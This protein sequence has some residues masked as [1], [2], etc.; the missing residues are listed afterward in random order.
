VQEN[1]VLHNNIFLDTSGISIFDQ[2][3]QFGSVIQGNFTAILQA[4]LGGDT[5]LKQTGLVPAGTESLR[6]RART[7]GLDS[8]GGFG[9]TL[10]GQTL[11][12]IPVGNG[13]NYTQFAADIHSWAGQTAELGFTVFAETPHVDNRYVDLDAIVF[14]PEPAPEPSAGALTA[15]GALLLGSRRRRKTRM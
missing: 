5:S 8:S 15:V 11:S 6:F 4:G 3:F 14:S 7:G 13:P 10:G 9:V 2:G 12:L 1:A